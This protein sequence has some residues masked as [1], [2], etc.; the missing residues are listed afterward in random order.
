MFGLLFHLT[1]SSFAAPPKLIDH[2][3][4]VPPPFHIAYSTVMAENAQDGISFKKP[5]SGHEDGCVMGVCNERA[6]A[7]GNDGVLHTPMHTAIS[8]RAG[9]LA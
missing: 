8:I 7:R 2:W 6:S 3:K 4:P 1:A 9:R 5:V